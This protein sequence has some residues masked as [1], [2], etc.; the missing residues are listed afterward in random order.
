MMIKNT[1]PKWVNGLIWT[2]DQEA[3]ARLTEAEII[4]CG[5]GKRY[6][7]SYTYYHSLWWLD[8]LL[9]VL[10]AR[11]ALTQHFITNYNLMSGGNLFCSSGNGD[12]VLVI[13]LDWWLWVRELVTFQLQFMHF[14]FT[15]DS[16]L[17]WFVPF[18]VTLE[19]Y[20]L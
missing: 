8:V 7:C 4:V 12:A 10:Y 3:T 6:Y 13:L 15:V 17:K 5:S 20:L 19:F 9:R 18:L 11:T 14:L 1:F 16:S 2:W